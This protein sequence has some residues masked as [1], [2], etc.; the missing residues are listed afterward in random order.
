ERIEEERRIAIEQVRLLEAQAKAA[1]KGAK[2]AYDLDEAFATLYAN[3]EK[4]YDKAVGDLTAGRENDKVI[5]AL[6]PT[7]G[8][9]SNAE[10]LIK[11]YGTALNLA[12]QEDPS[13]FQ[14]VKEKMMDWLGLD[15]KDL[16]IL[17]QSFKTLYDEVGALMTEH[18]DRQLDQNDRLLEAIKAQSE[19]VQS[20]LE[21]QME[22]QA[23]GRSNNV[24]S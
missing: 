23:Q 14:E 19:V 9:A 16:A 17:S 1:A 13:A 15:D 20:E 7:T 6:L 12:F 2:A 8:V 3:I 18:I 11:N 24:E 21:H 5:D 4:G 22:L 10:R